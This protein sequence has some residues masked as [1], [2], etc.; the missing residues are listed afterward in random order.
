VTLPA[1]PVAGP[2]D[3]TRLTLEPLRIGHAEEMA[4]ALDD[5]GLHEFIGG[6][7]ANVEELRARYAFQVIGHS[8]EDDEGWLNWVIRRRDTRDV[9]GTVQ[10]TLRRTGP[11]LSADVAW[12]VASGHQGQGLASEASAAMVAWLRS[13]GVGQIVALVHPDHGASAKV[14]RHLGLVPTG[15]LVDG[16]VRWD[17]APSAED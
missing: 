12:V 10:A 11:D 8:P 4:P 17:S 14:A 13:Q 9:V 15:D 5:P 6:S 1:W 2:I 16:E 7:P 3:T